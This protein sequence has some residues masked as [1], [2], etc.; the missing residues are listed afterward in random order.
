MTDFLGFK[1]FEFLTFFLLVG[2]WGQ[3]MNILGYGNFAN[4]L[5]G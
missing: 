2:G 1:F 5:L 3:K 4:I